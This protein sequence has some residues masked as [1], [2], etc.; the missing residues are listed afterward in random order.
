MRTEGQTGMTK[1]IIAFRN[2]AK[3]PNKNTKIHAFSG[4]RTRNLSNQVASDLRIN[5]VHTVC[6][7]HYALFE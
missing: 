7:E 3:A 6:Q 4:I 2:F 1:L 5:M